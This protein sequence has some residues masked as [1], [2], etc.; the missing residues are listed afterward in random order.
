LN[1]P[2]GKRLQPILPDLVAR[3]EH[4]GELTL[5]VTVRTQLLAMSAASIDRFLAAERRRLEIKGRTGTKPGTLLK[6]QIPVRTWAEW[7]DAT[8]PGFL[9]IDLVSH[10]GGA[11]RGDFAWT[12]DMVDILT[13]W[14][15]TAALP[16]KARKWVVDALDAHRHQFPFPI[17]GIDSDNGS[18]FINHHL[19][20]WCDTHHITF[21]RSRAYHKNDGCYVEQKNWTVVRRFV[22]YVRYEGSE[23]VAWLN[24]LYATLRLYTN[25]FQ[26]LQKTVTKERQGA[27]VTRRYDR[28]QTPYQRVLALSDDLV[29]PDQKAALQAQYETLNPAELRRTLTRL[30]DQLWATD[31]VASATAPIISVSD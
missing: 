24:A 12:L 6:H 31:P 10:D 30:Q 15:E 29:S 11:A 20:A 8:Q 7:D 4:F 19:V 1:F 3:L 27:R 16:N 25:F 14:T 13:G 18:E 17:R 26:P 5:D 28:A 9:E 23:P 2:T 22:G 21:T